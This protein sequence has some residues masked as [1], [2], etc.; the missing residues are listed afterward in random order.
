[1]RV[2]EVA[3]F[4][5]PE[6]MQVQNREIPVAEP[7]TI[8]VRLRAV[9]VNPVE[10][11]IRAGTY[12]VLPELPYV[13]GG[14]GAGIIHE[15]GQGVNGF[16]VGQ[17]VYVAARTGTYGE[18]CCCDVNEIHP[19]PENVTFEEGAALGVPAVTAYR[20]LFIRGEARKGEKVLIHG[21]SG[22]VGVAAIQL[23]VA[24][25]MEVTGTAGSEK[26]L[27]MIKANGAF[28]VAHNGEYVAALREAAPGG[29]DL[30]LEMLANKNL[31]TDLELLAPH[32]RVVIIGSRGRIE[33]DP[34]ATMG[35]E[36]DIRGLALANSTAEEL[37]QMHEEIFK[38]LTAGV[39]KPVVSKTMPLEDAAQAHHQVMENGNCGKIVLIP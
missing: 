38:A 32:G 16:S 20:A 23:G 31:E 8:V 34:R 2:I 26:G 22:S 3:T 36:T 17:R 28:P 12:P 5:K 37:Q 21:G 14:N 6:V 11:Y 15:V 24:A 10:T 1:M 30:I 18:Y 13:P 29:Y 7:G 25:G 39:L 19:L 27:E 9:G 4:G 33:I 35:K